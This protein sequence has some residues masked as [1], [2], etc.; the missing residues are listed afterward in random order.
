MEALPH[1]LLLI[2]CRM[3][4][5]FRGVTGQ[6]PTQRLETRSYLCTHAIMVLPSALRVNVMPAEGG[7]ARRALPERRLPHRLGCD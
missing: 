3:P 6:T 5:L 7:E 2:G 4:L 1:P